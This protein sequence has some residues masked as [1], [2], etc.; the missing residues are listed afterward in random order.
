MICCIF[1]LLRPTMIH[2]ISHLLPPAN[3][4]GNCDFSHQMCYVARFL[5]CNG[6]HYM[7][8]WPYHVTMEWQ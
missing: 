5:W 3:E 6:V 1:H 4:H 7:A 8:I 2:C